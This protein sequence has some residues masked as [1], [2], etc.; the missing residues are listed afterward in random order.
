[1]L[2]K[3]SVPFFLVLRENA[4]FSLSRDR[5]TKIKELLDEYEELVLLEKKVSRRIWDQSSVAVY[6]DGS[7]LNEETIQQRVSAL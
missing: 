3:K 1:M 7:K 5:M 4:F 2:I 6:L